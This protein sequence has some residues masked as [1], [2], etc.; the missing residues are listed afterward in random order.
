[1]PDH[2]G[3]VGEIGGPPNFFS[4]QF[5]YCLRTLM[6]GI[7]MMV[8]SQNISL[9][10]YTFSSFLILLGQSH[11]DK[12]DLSF[13]VKMKEGKIKTCISKYFTFIMHNAK[14]VNSFLFLIRL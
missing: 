3:E 11:G 2:V 8:L 12:T 4:T 13:V 10:S 1:M 14:P 6:Y 5:S 9:A 7:K